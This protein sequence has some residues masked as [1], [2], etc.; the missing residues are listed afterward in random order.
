[1]THSTNI[2]PRSVDYDQTLVLAIELS[3]KS[4]VLAAQVP[5][6]SQRNGLSS[7]I[8]MI[9]WRRLTPTEPELLPLAARS[10]A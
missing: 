8:K 2:L 10:S 9:C 1:M 7:R 5:G 4:W 3:N 6:L